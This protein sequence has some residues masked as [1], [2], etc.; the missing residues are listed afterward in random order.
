MSVIQ[1]EAPSEE[2]VTLQELKSHCVIDFD[3]DDDY[4]KALLKVAR[5]VIERE[6]GLLFVEQ[7]WQEEFTCF[8]SAEVEL[9][10]A[11]VRSIESIKYVDS[12]G[13]DQELSAEGFQACLTAFP[14]VLAP[15]YSHCWPSVR[16]GFGA[17]KV[18]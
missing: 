1:I 12:S 16:R 13:V 17:V 5:E 15:A 6:A 18:R 11:P 4:L 7:T 2:P 3:D 9:S 14:A 8:S 10:K